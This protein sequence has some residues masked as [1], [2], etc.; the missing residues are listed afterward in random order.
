MQSGIEESYNEQLG[1]EESDDDHDVLDDEPIKGLLTARRNQRLHIADSTHSNHLQTG[2][3][4]WKGSMLTRLRAADSLQDGLNTV[5][6][7]VDE[8]QRVIGGRQSANSNQSTKLASTNDGDNA[9]SGQNVLDSLSNSFDKFFSPS[10]TKSV[11]SAGAKSISSAGTKSSASTGT[12]SISSTGESKPISPVGTKS[13][14]SAGAK[15]ISPDVRKRSYQ[16]P[17]K[18]VLLDMT[19][20][21]PR[22]ELANPHVQRDDQSEIFKVCI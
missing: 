20:P 12:K 4:D 2:C 15:S 10:G 14:S 16:R 11:S 18:A 1:N 19:M 8:Q 3:D 13:N 17:T 21:A 5:D 7:V 6:E 9:E 22:A